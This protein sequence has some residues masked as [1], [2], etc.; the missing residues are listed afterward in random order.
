[1]TQQDVESAFVFR[2][3][4]AADVRVEG[5][6]IVEIGPV[7]SSGARVLDCRGLV[8][9]PG[10]IDAHS[11]SDLRAIS[12]PALPMKV[13]QGI[14]T[15]VFGQDG[16]SVAPVL[17]QDV[18]ARRRQL[19]GL[20]G[21]P[22][23]PW[24]WG[25]V[26][27]YLDTVRK[28]NPAVDVA[29]LIPHGAVRQCA[30]GMED[31]APTPE[32]LRAMERLIDEGMSEG[33]VGMSTGLIYPPCCYAKTDELMAL[34]RVIARQDGVFVAHI[35]N[36]GDFIVPALEELIRV[37]RESGCRIHVS[38]LKIAGRENWS[39]V[40]AVVRL[41]EAARKDLELSADQYPYIAGSTGMG[42]IL[43]PW[44]HDGGVD[45]A[46]R[47]LGD[48]ETR[49][50]IRTM[51]LDPRPVEW[52]NFWRWSGPE[53]ILI[54]DI[55][56]GRRPELLG[57]NLRDGAA[58]CDPLDFAMDLLRDE[59]MGVSLVS[60]S[61]CEEVIE[62]FLRLPF[63]GVCTDGLLGGRP[64]PRAYGTYPRLLGR[65][66]RER[67]VLS[68]EDALRK[69][70]AVSAKAYRLKGVGAIEVGARAN[71]V[72]FDPE[73]VADRATFEDPCR[74]SEGI[75]YV[76]RGGELVYDATASA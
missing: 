67:R 58:G 72:A 59:R 37:G 28:A 10:F 44:V 52:D 31:R 51:V 26:G 22:V 40:E 3:A 19:A 14:T 65:Y 29:Y 50:R 60:F 21:D 54:S 5:S 41:L 48:A 6:R 74:Y 17:P 25:S 11:H 9:T 55:P 68:L 76:M 2:N 39:K 73:R 46:T 35:R 45:E 69:T 66:V 32:E 42:A 7:S 38:H 64:H 24:T 13:R 57:K 18:P 75:V 70:S 23:L 20:L 8:V 4:R 49:R 47:R 62:A 27:Q 43:P 12:E 15:E 53:G 16:I 61:Q 36:E 1:M 33:A 30:M 63:V 56:S 34:A 71:L